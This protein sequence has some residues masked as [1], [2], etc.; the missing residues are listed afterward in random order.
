MDLPPGAANA[1]QN[2]ALENYWTLFDDPVLNQLVDE[3]LANNLDLKASLAR[4]E[5]ARA[6]RP[7]TW[8]RPGIT[9]KRCA[10]PWRPTSP[11]P[12]SGCARRTP[13]S[14]CWRTH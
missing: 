3:A 10:S 11:R 5:A 14:R 1:A 4:I 9:A 7:T 2:Q 8:P 13:S 6:P 12:I